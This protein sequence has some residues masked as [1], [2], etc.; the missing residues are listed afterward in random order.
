[1]HGGDAIDAMG[2]D[3]GE[4]PH[5][6]TAAGCFV[7]QRHGCPVVGVR[8]RM[9]VRRGKVFEIDPINNIEMARQT[10]VRIV[11]PAR[12]RAPPA[13]ACDWCRRLFW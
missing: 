6:N 10:F 8:P 7:D 4:M 1:M 13:T 3:E 9:F 5:P 2:A 11:R 12:S